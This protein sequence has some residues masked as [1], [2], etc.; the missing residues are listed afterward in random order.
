MTKVPLLAALL[1]VSFVA[2]PVRAQDPGA[3]FRDPV[4]FGVRVRER[5]VAAGLARPA[6]R[7]L[8]FVDGAARP[9]V[10]FQLSNV[11]DSLY[12][13]VLPLV[14][15]YVED[16]ASAEPFHL[17]VLLEGMLPRLPRDTGEVA[18]EQ[19]PELANP[20]QL[21]AYLTNVARTHPSSTD[22]TVDV[23]SLVRVYVDERGQV[24]LVEA[25]PTGDPFIDVHL[26]SIGH[27]MRFRPARVNRRPVPVWIAM[28]LHFSPAG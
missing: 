26:T 2:A 5:L 7:V 17:S 27:A 13:V 15:E 28:P 1:A 11:P 3:T 12:G 10:S 23:R 20:S 18:S 8:L 25:R 6:G 21:R 24:V 14:N 19:L 4:P 22:G 16:R 9:R